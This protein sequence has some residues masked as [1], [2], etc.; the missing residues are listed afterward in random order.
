[1]NI[2][3]ETINQEFIERGFA[4]EQWLDQHVRRYTRLLDQ[5]DTMS[6]YIDNQY[7]TELIGGVLVTVPNVLQVHVQWLTITLETFAIH[8]ITSACPPIYMG[9]Q[10]PI[11][12]TLPALAGLLAP[13]HRSLWITDGIPNAGL[14]AQYLHTVG[15][16]GLCEKARDC[17]PELN[18][19]GTHSHLV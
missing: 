14:L 13:D 11:S 17:N 4:H 8:V 1:M 16:R 18:H 6:M 2:T 19:A 12:Q 5:P 15:L 3:A 7:D 10:A 9:Y